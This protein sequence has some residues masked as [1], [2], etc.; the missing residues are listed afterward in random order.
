MRRYLTRLVIVNALISAFFAAIFAAP[1]GRVEVGFIAGFVFGLAAGLLVEV[2]FRRWQGRWL[3]RR[4]LLVLVLLEVLLVLYLVLPAYFAYFSLR[5]ARIPV[6]AIPDVLA[7]RVEEVSM[8]TSDGISLSGWYIPA[9]NGAVIITLHGMGSNRLG[10]L[11]HAQMLMENDYGVL[12]MDM[13]AHG[14]SGGEIFAEGWNAPVDMAAMVAYLHSRPEIRQIGAL[15]LSA[16]AVSILHTGAQNE[17][18]GAFVADGIGV[19]AASDLLDPLTPHPAVALLL[20]PDYWTSC[21]FTA[22]FTGLEPAPPLRDQVKRIAPRPML[23]IAGEESNWEPELAAKYAASA[24]DAAE[25]WV[26]PQTGH[27]AGVRT[28]PEEY[29]TRVIGFLNAALLEGK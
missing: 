15:G 27:I 12:M 20:V 7:G 23:F 25:V 1:I 17:A 10:V 3:Y 24:G 21:R 29:R 18:I 28:A 19:G 8:R 16:G 14:S 11:P 4:R 5:P 13:R 6:T 9:Q 22:L 26:I 2:I